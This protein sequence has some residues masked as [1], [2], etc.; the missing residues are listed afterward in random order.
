M[1]KQHLKA[2]QRK[3]LNVEAKQQRI[4]VS[5]LKQRL[6][7]DGDG[8]NPAIPPEDNIIMS[9]DTY[10]DSLECPNPASNTSNLST[11]VIT[12]TMLC[13]V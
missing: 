13:P 3:R 9:R 1:P 10:E 6:T 2:E 7:S 5:E 4:S 11:I 12:Y 8:D